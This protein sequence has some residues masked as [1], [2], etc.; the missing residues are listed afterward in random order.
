[1]SE[2]E[3]DN[4][5]YQD[6]S[7]WKIDSRDLLPDSK[8]RG[9]EDAQAPESTPGSESPLA[10]VSPLPGKGTKR[11]EKTPKVGRQAVPSLDLA[12]AQPGSQATPANAE[13]SVPTGGYQSA[14]SP[15]ETPPGTPASAPPAVGPAADISPPLSEVTPPLPKCS[16][17]TNPHRATVSIHRDPKDDVPGGDEGGKATTTP[18]RETRRDPLSERLYLFSF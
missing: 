13:G 4:D 1:M 6:V 9:S 18:K 11:K 5:L 8:P 14:D 2:T 10:Q 16:V 12:K 15:V 3:S 17:H 7:P